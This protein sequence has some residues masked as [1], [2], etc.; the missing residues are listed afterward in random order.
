[1]LCTKHMLLF[2]RCSF[3]HL[4]CARYCSQYWGY[5][6][7]WNSSHFTWTSNFNL[8]S[9]L[10]DTTLHIT[11]ETQGETKEIAHSHTARKW[12][13]VESN[14]E[15]SPKSLLPWPA[16]CWCHNLSCVCTY[17]YVCMYTHIYM[18]ILDLFISCLLQ[19]QWGWIL[20]L[21]CWPVNSQCWEQHP[22]HSWSS[23]NIYRTLVNTCWTEGTWMRRAGMSFLLSKFVLASDY[24]MRCWPSLA[25]NFD[26]SHQV[27]CDPSG[28]IHTS[29]GALILADVFENKSFSKHQVLTELEQEAIL[30]DH[31]QYC[32]K[33][34]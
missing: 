13:K 29:S 14:P 25:A 16:H 21:P 18:Y 20:S 1:M 26:C 8:H 10:Q 19:P 9:N 22:A 31:Q 24:L 12:S 6:D 3:G 30:E 27:P 11:W 17:M 23:V 32:S 2:D 5:S 15:Q 28:W 34:V 4:L 7:K 33:G